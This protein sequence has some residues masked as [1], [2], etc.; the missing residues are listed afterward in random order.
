VLIWDPS[1]GQIIDD[2]SGEVIMEHLPASGYKDRETHTL[3]GYGDE[4]HPLHLTSARFSGARQSILMVREACGLDHV[5]GEREVRRLL[6][7]LEQ[8]SGTVEFHLALV[9]VICGLKGRFVVIKQF[10]KKYGANWRRVLSY[11]REIKKYIG[12]QRLPGEEDSV[13][14]DY[15]CQEDS[16]CR[17][18]LAKVLLEIPEGKRE[19]VAF[20]VYYDYLAVRLAGGV[21]EKQ[22]SG[23]RKH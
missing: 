9:Y 1:R 7:R 22:V 5:E 6:K 16:G 18:Y 14:I 8:Y 11:I 23:R 2:E 17:D 10:S 15:F 3:L 13:I 20:D 19:V 12:V 4:E 21:L